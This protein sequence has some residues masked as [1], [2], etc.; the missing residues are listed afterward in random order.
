MD[1][2]EQ[3]E[4]AAYHLTAAM[5]T[6]QGLVREGNEDACLILQPGGQIALLAIADGM[7]GHAAGEVASAYAIAALQAAF[8]DFP[9]NPPATF[10]RALRDANAA[11][12]A[13][14][15]AHADCAGMGTTCTALSIA[16]G[17]AHLAHIGDSRA[18]VGTAE[19]LRQISTD[20]S[21]VG[22]L[23]EA[24]LITPD[25]AATHPQRNVITQ[26]LGT[27]P[28]FAPQI[29]TLPLAL[30]LG[31]RFLI[32]SD[33]LSDLVPEAEIYEAL[34]GLAPHQACDA[35]IDAALQAGG[36][37]NVSVGILSLGPAGAAP[38]DTRPAAPQDTG[39]LT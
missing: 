27:A 5:R 19:G 8:S 1:S 11:I 28:E 16:D 22:R 29:L 39:A 23:L 6:D 24:G 38:G 9:D 3:S 31:Q 12:L 4:A 7:G 18:Y 25:E 34:M 20:H 26:A 15:G 2:T 37:D 21:A 35:L 36:L 14:A 33:G 10:A 13:H 30:A 32:C 17:R